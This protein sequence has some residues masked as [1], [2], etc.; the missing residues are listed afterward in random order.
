MAVQVDIPGV[1]NVIA[2]NAAQ[3]DTLKEIL[4]A[5]KSGRGGGSGGGAGAGA[6]GGAGGVGPEM[7]KAKK[8]TGEFS[9]SIADT[10]TFV[11]DFGS[12][13]RKATKGLLGFAGDLLGSAYDFGETLLFTGNRMSDLAGAIPL[14]GGPLGNLVGLAE[15]LVDNFRNLSE[16]GA[17]FSNNI[18]NIARAAANAEM[19]LGMFAETVAQNSNELS[20]LGGSVT[21]GA[22]RFGRISKN[23]RTSEQDFLGMGYTM[24]G[25]NEG[26]IAYTEEMARS[27]RLR[28]MSD[29]QLTQGAGV[30]L[31]E[32][33]KLAKVTGMT[34]KEAEA[35]RVQQQG[36]ARMRNMINKLEGKARENLTNSLAFLDN[37]VPGLSDAFK[38]LADGAAQTEEGMMLMA[39]GGDEFV[40]LAQEM[41]S[42]ELD[43]AELNNR[44]MELA[45]LIEKNTK[46]MSEAQLQAL[47][48]TNPA[49]YKI[50]SSNSDLLALTKKDAEAIAEENKSRDG[51]T[52]SLAQV[53]QN[54]ATIR[55]NLY[56]EFLE[57]DIFKMITDTLG[58]LAPKTEDVSAFM[59][60]LTPIVKDVI[61]SFTKFVNDF[62]ADPKGTFDKIVDNIKSYVGNFFSSMFDG[63]GTKI[64]A[65]ILAG[66]LLMVTGVI[67]GP[68]L[69]IGAGLALI[70]G[71][72]K[73][74]ELG[75]KYIWEPIKSMFGWLGD[76]FGSLWESIK[77]FG[78]KLNPLNWF[79]GDDEEQEK[80]VAEAYEPDAP[81]I[82]KAKMDVSNMDAA[83][84]QAL[85]VKDE[86]VDAALKA[87]KENDKKVKEQANKAMADSQKSVNTTDGGNMQVALLQEQNELLRALLRTTKSNTSDM[88]SS[89]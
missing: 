26:L 37:K 42:G 78:S 70:F 7:K 83:Q 65:G 56:K 27:G 29:A 30:Y 13:L 72:D 35:A 58:D 86:D 8:E 66:L 49:L 74:L 18:F 68:F 64:A 62:I 10:T 76:W 39:M 3:E 12:G 17:G 19:P 22:K 9:K 67:T 77:G 53:E 61:E 25:V 89:A 38:D 34:R 73:I 57:S 81:T 52:Q 44:L 23:L 87:S 4:K 45:P 21:E 16:S 55:G 46:N 79:G 32:L 11:D 59:E 5:L 43:P 75:N 14:V 48:Q 63:L 6:G 69:A 60:K 80:K 33:D 54:L 51:V 88:Y 50:L 1:G 15:G 84:L 82:K 40:K 36:D 24:E 2:K 47:E 85:E 31:M 71:A 20:R 41:A 28:G